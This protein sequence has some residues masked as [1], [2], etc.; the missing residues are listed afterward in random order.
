MKNFIEDSKKHIIENNIGDNYC[1]IV[2]TTIN[3]T[4]NIKFVY[5]TIDDFE[6]KLIKDSHNINDIFGV[7]FQLWI[8]D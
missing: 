3:G 1:V 7:I 8:F 4:R 6:K 5:K 2:Y